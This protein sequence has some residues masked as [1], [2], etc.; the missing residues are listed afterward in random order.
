[1]LL[2]EDNEAVA[3]ATAEFLRADG[4]TVERVPHGEAALERLDAPGQHAVDV[5][6]SDI[7]MPG[8]IDGVTLA[9]MLSRRE[10]PLPVVLMSGYAT[11]MEQALREGLEVLPKPCA[12][13][14][15]AEAIAKA[16]R[17]GRQPA[18]L[19]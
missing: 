12:P 14:M 10:P 2:V 9:G 19:A 15:L 1:V 8:R 7:E 3:E 13:T 5:V 6:L 18:A 16:H 17:P 11:R 4:C